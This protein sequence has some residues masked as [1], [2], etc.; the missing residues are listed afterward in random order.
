VAKVRCE[1]GRVLFFVNDGVM[2]IRCPR[3][4]H[5]TRVVVTPS[6]QPPPERR[7]RR[8]AGSGGAGKESQERPER[9]ED[10]SRKESENVSQSE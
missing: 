3:S 8:A 2:E 7:P 9:R 10:Q 6:F 4:G 1:C 5:V